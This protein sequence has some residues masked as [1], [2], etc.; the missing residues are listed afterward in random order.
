MGGTTDKA[1]ML[2]ENEL[3]LLFDEARTFSG[4]LKA[5]VPEATLRKLY[6]H[7]RWGPTSMNS[8]PGRFVFVTTDAARERLKPHLMPLNVD[9]VMSAP[10]TVI[11]ARD[12]QYYEEAETLFPAR[13]AMIKENAP[14][15]PAI[16]RDTSVRN[17][18][19]MGGY[20]ILAARALGLDC[21]AMSGF[22]SETLN[23]DFFPD[24]RWE[25]DFLCNIGYGDPASLHPRNPRLT[26]ETACRIM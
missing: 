24:G 25:A 11:V 15:M 6:D 3:A 20:M 10:V 18:T 12:T 5:P 1:G 17:A 16:V 4:F 21:G 8:S 26:F 13:G 19:L 22:N 14:K 9:K 23:K 2:G 7:L